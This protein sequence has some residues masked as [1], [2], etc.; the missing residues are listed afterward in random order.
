MENNEVWNWAKI[1]EIYSKPLKQ[2]RVEIFKLSCLIKCNFVDNKVLRPRIIFNKKA[3]KELELNENSTVTFFDIE[4][5]PL[6]VVNST[7]IDWISA[8]RKNEINIKFRATLTA[9]QYEKIYDGAGIAKGEDYYFQL[10]PQTTNI[11]EQN[12]TM[13]TFSKLLKYKARQRD[14]NRSDKQRA[15]DANIKAWFEQQKASGND[16]VTIKDYWNNK[17]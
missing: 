13:Y 17:D 5:K 9:K 7:N 16:K 6:T 4:D 15:S 3:A 12:I 1:M 8:D 11:G 14:N 10:I 2:S